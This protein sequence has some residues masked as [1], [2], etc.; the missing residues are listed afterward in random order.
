MVGWTPRRRWLVALE[1]EFAEIERIHKRIDDPDRVVLVDPVIETFG[2]Q[3]RLPAIRPSI[4]R[5]I[6]SPP[7][8]H[9][10]NHS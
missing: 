4:K 3:C 6:G 2:Q 9:R 7:A 5:F 1:A 10:R 8:N